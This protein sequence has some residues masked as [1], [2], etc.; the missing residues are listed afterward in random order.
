[1]FCVDTE[2][3]ARMRQALVN[4]KSGARSTR[5]RRPRHA[6]SRGHAEVLLHAG[7]VI[8]EVGRLVRAE[9]Q[10][11]AR[12]IAA[13]AELDARRLY[14]AQGCSSLFVYCTR[15]LHLSE[16]AAYGRIE[17][18]RAARKFPVLLE[19]LA[20][21]DLTL[22]AVGLLAP[23]LTPDNHRDVLGRAKHKTRREVEEIV[24][25]LRPLPDARPLVRKLPAPSPS[26]PSIE[27]RAAPAPRIPPPPPVPTSPAATV[28]Q[29]PAT[30]ITPARQER[31]VVKP[32]AKIGRRAAARRAE[33]LPGSR[34]RRSRHSK[35]ARFC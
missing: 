32:L 27:D 35:T 26:K 6:H 7:G 4:E 3:A 13:L 1:M 28:E 18:A 33:P 25:V 14:L 17:A 12:L 9:R 20:A 34:G 24:A 23:H 10:A 16:H 2:H 19:M 30:P 15:V 5:D 31:A 29:P 21:S 11:T 8:D 22:T